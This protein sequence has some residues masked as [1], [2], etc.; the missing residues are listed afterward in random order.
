MNASAIAITSQLLDRIAEQV[1]EFDL[2]RAV[3][4][5]DDDGGRSTRRWSSTAAASMAVTVPT[6]RTTARTCTRSACMAPLIPDHIGCVVIRPDGSR[7][8]ARVM[9]DPL[10]DP[11]E[12]TQ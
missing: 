1:P 8:L 4:R 3:D 6:S 9:P 2:R 5:V 12:R 10:A 7:Y 11:P